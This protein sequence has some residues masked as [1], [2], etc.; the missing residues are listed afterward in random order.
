MNPNVKDMTE[1]DNPMRAM[2]FAALA[3]F[4]FAVMGA[5]TKVMTETHHVVEIIFYRNALTILPVF[6]YLYIKNKSLFQVRHPG[7]L[8]IRCIGGIISMAITFFALKHLPYTD[9][10]VLT[11]LTTLLTPL[12]AHFLLKERVGKYRMVAILTGLCG[13]LLIIQPSGNA[14]TALGL[15]LGIA[16]AISHSAMF[17]VLRTLKSMPAITIT[18]YFILTGTIMAGALMPWFAQSVSALDLLAFLTI[19]IFGGVGQY[20]ITSAN[21]SGTPSLVVPF[22]YTGLIWASGFD[23]IIWHHIPNLNVYLGALVIIAA[24][25]YILYREHKKKAASA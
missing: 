3:F 7:R 13:A 5:I 19:G 23:I 18:F 24:K 11:F 14:V 8:A 17:L 20:C 1:A 12:G 22:T 21:R 4:L 10:T 6:L 9:F 25:A 15:A 16:T 2:G